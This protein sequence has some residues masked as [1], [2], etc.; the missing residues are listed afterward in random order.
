MK[1]DLFVSFAS[2]S[3]KSFV[4]PFAY[5]L[6]LEGFLWTWFDQRMIEDNKS[7]SARIDEGLKNSWTGAIFA[8][9]RY[10]EKYWTMKE[11][12]TLESLRAP[13]FVFGLDL[14]EEDCEEWIPN[15]KEHAITFVDAREGDPHIYAS[16]LVELLSPVHG[17]NIQTHRKLVHMQYFVYDCLQ[18]YI[19]RTLGLDDSCPSVKEIA[20][21]NNERLPALHDFSSLIPRFFGIDEHWVRSK[22]EMIGR[23]DAIFT[24]NGGRDRGML[25]PKDPSA[26]AQAVLGCAIDEKLFTLWL[27]KADLV[28][29]LFGGMDM[30]MSP[31][32]IREFMA[33]F[34]KS[35]AIVESLR[36]DIA[37][38][39]EQNDQP[40]IEIHPAWHSKNSQHTGP[41]C[42]VSFVGEKNETLGTCGAEDGMVRMWNVATGESIKEQQAGPE[43][44]DLLRASHD[45]RYQMW[46][47]SDT[48]NLYDARASRT[49]AVFKGH[50]GYVSSATVTKDLRV[51]L[52]GG[53]DKTVR[54]WD[55]V[56]GHCTHILKGHEER[57]LTVSLSYDGKLAVSGSM[58]KTLRLW[59]IERAVCVGTLEGHSEG[60]TVCKL[61]PDSRY[62]L[63]G[64][65]DHTVRL[66]DVVS[67]KWINTLSLYIEPI[68]ISEW[69]DGDMV[70]CG[71]K[72]GSVV[73]V[74]VAR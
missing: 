55:A 66:W 43:A 4:I 62:V 18:V 9:R 33:G 15:M 17:L 27:R 25:S 45:Q 3:R 38:G 56:Q 12:R 5:T 40:F 41:V 30:T 63:S 74:H 14:S 42:S 8:S 71:C 49:I 51:A 72:D 70:A 6:Y 35:G 64:S 47:N 2:E 65:F 69:T 16:A 11:L 54:V 60:V 7:L 68:A 24:L 28:L 59:D 37:Q 29:D 67:H 21:R 46:R 32:E 31:S 58:D 26:V 44:W 10:F 19:N 1:W 13:M 34:R 61:S 52:S 39:D 57:V 22:S 23:F 73:V 50:D 20:Q 48:F 36:S 53:R